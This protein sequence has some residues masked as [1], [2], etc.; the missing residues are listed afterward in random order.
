MP[1][2]L[3]CFTTRFTSKHMSNEGAERLIRRFHASRRLS[4]RS[5][6]SVVNSNTITMNNQCNQF[7]VIIRPAATQLDLIFTLFE[8]WDRVHLTPNGSCSSFYTI[9]WQYKPIFHWLI[10]REFIYY[11]GKKNST[12]QNGWVQCSSGLRNKNPR[13]GRQQL[14]N[15]GRHLLFQNAETEP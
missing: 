8:K 2:Y 3:P 13:F 5:R 12:P 6:S 9:F 14:E 10:I 4:S 11:F 1:N 15:L 7:D